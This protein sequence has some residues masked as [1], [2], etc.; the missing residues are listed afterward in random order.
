MNST[1][2]LRIVKDCISRGDFAR[3][4]P[5]LEKL[6]RLLK[7]DYDNGI[8][9]T[10]NGKAFNSLLKVRRELLAGE[11]SDASYALLKLQAPRKAEPPKPEPPKP[12]PPKP[13]PK[14]ADDD[15]WNVRPAPDP[16]PSDNAGEEEIIEIENP[17]PA[18]VKERGDERDFEYADASGE[19]YGKAGDGLVI[20]KYNGD[21]EEVTVPASYE[22]KAVVALGEKAFAGNTKIT[23]VHLPDSIRYVSGFYGCSALRSVNIPESVVVIASEAFSQCLG[24]EMLRIPS[25]VNEIG[26]LAFYMC[27]A[28]V[29]VD[30]A[31]KAYCNDE[32][33]ALLDKHKVRLIRFPVL[34]RDEKYE[35]PR[36]I[37]EIEPF[38]F[39]GCE[40]LQSVTLPVGLEKIGQRA[41]EKCSFPSIRIP[42]GVE[43][44]DS[45]AFMGEALTVMC[46]VPVK[47][48]EWA[49]DWCVG[50]NVIWGGASSDEFFADLPPLD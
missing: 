32:C 13:A 28:D 26:G 8:N 9:R 20:V 38:A 1:D 29:V 18:P 31:N 6:L 40:V 36:S 39:A 34:R 17:E 33:G 2:L 11:L 43:R 12:E 47:P 22:G 30:P 3:A 16:I 25:S 21:K 19:I 23:A 46:D 10:Q 42:S 41:F 27:G 14:P 48:E 45:E 37:Q 5:P 7:L 15:I 35:L 4:V 50:A 49:A 24:L 44:I